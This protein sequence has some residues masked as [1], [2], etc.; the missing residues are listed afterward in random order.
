MY[1]RHE[2][3]VEYL[4]RCWAEREAVRHYHDDLGHSWRETAA[5]YRITEGAAKQR[6]Y[7]AR[8]E[9]KAEAQR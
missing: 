3:R 9:L 8:R 7:R 1:R 6:V 5:Q 2:S 4:D